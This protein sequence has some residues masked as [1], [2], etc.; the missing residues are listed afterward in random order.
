MMTFDIS[1]L[2]LRDPHGL[3][4]GKRYRDVCHQVVSTATPYCGVRQ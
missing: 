3:K 2:E 1:V 4:E